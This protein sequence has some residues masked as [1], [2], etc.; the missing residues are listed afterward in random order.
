[1]NPIPADVLERASHIR[2]V[3]MDVDGVLTDG[4]FYFFPGPDGEIMETKAFDSQDG[5]ALQ[6]L[7]RKGIAAGLISGRVSPATAERATSAGF[8]YVYQGNLEKIPIIEE[9]RAQ[10]GLDESQIAY[11]GDD[12][13]D[14]VVMH[15]VG[16]AIATQN[17]AQPVKDEADYVTA[18]PG[19]SGAVREAVELIL[20]AQGLWAEILQQY[21]IGSEPGRRRR[22]ARTSG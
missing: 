2:L 16:L 5:M 7:R 1:M 21:E 13:T 14:V 9:I 8:R 15:R 19:G 3:L 6:W 10:S 4:K 12:F 22:P 17:A 11:I 18:A 20:R